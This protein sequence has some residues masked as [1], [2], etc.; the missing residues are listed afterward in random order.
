MNKK[1][2]IQLVVVLVCFGGSA[3]VIYNGFF[4]KS[5]NQLVSQLPGAVG[6]TQNAGQPE[7][8][9]PYGDKLE[10]DAVL[11]KKNLRY[12]QINYPQVNTSSEVGTPLEQLIGTPLP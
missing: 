9:L 4:S 10:F 12:E 1:K 3:M 5:S 7:K 11:N 2:I 8:V 6:Q